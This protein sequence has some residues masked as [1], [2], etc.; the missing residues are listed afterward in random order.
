VDQD[1]NRKSPRTRLRAAVTLKHPSMGEH[2]TH[3]RDISDGGAFVLTEGMAL[4]AMGEIVEVQVQ[5]LPGEPAPIV[6]MRVVRIDK[7]GI[8]LEFIEDE[9]Q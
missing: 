2:Q 3:T 9:A 1:S 8:G 4:P 6:R 5:G 7:D